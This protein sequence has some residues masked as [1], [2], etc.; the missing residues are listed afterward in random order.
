MCLSVKSKI[1]NWQEKGTSKSIYTR[2]QCNTIIKTQ[3]PLSNRNYGLLANDNSSFSC[4]QKLCHKSC[5]CRVCSQDVGK[6][7]ALHNYISH[8]NA[9]DNIHTRKPH[10]L[11]YIL[12]VRFDLN[13]APSQNQHCM[14]P[15]AQTVSSNL[16]TSTQ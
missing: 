14:I 13:Y 9:F 16:R 4:R 6:I 5:T 3:Q 2:K 10:C 8:R 15:S 11:G 12:T 1:C 7:Y